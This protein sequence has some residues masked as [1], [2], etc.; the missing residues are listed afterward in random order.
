MIFQYI[1][2]DFARNCVGYGGPR[3]TL[4]TVRHFLETLENHFN[5]SRGFF[6]TG[7]PTGELVTGDARLRNEFNQLPVLAR[8]RMHRANHAHSTTIAIP[9][10]HC[11]FC[12]GLHSIPPSKTS[13]RVRC[14]PGNNSLDTIIAPILSCSAKVAF[15]DPYLRLTP[16][17]EATR[18]ANWITNSPYLTHIAFIRGDRDA[19]STFI[20][21]INSLN[22]MLG[23]ARW[24]ALHIRAFVISEATARL[25]ARY[26]HTDQ[27]TLGIEG[28]FQ[29]QSCG[30]DE[31]TDVFILDSHQEIDDNYIINRNKH[32]TTVS[33][34]DKPPN[35]GNT[36]QAAN[37]HLPSF[38]P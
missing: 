7:L 19:Y 28:G 37:I 21:H 34:W 14:W 11:S 33:A 5:P 36:L 10:Q 1:N 8:L 17:A 9:N 35:C 23:N 12:N 26:I 22:G 31:M 32:F 3:L 27:F 29:F 30:A 24:N 38:A 15:I 20:N 6:Y 13:T 4:G 25:H 2:L 18:F 16:N